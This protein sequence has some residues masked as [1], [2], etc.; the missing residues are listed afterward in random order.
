MKARTTTRATTSRPGRIRIILAAA[1]MILSL[2]LGGVVTAD[3]RNM[4]NTGSDTQATLP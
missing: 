4:T 2:A 1:W 3:A